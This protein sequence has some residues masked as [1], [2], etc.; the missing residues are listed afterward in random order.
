MSD[1]IVFGVI[2]IFV[3]D[4]G[5]GYYAAMNN[6]P[7]SVTLSYEMDFIVGRKSIINTGEIVVF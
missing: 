1:A 4:K 2:I 5:Q 6:Y 3:V 7:V